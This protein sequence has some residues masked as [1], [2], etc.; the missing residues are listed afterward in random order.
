MKAKLNPRQKN[1]VIHYL[2]TLNATKAA[3]LAG[4]SEKTAR[5]QGSKNL[6]KTNISEAINQGLETALDNEKTIFKYETLG[7]LRKI[8]NADIDN[9]EDSKVISGRTYTKDGEEQIKLFDKNTA[10]NTALKYMG[11]LDNDENNDIREIKLVVEL[12]D[13]YKI[14]DS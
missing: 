13:R 5:I 6:T 3:K 11:L 1:F 12:D 14:K 9:L 8:I 10:I 4:Y 7:M 2:Q